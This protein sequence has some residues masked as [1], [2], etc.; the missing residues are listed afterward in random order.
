[1]TEPETPQIVSDY[2]AQ[3]VEY[4]RRAVGI[5]VEYDSDT[6]P[7]VDHYLTTV[8]PEHV[9]TTKLVVAAV[10]AYFGE[11]AR[12]HLGG[13]WEL[14][15]DS[16]ESWRLVLPIGISFAPVAVVYAAVAREESADA[17]FHIPAVL[18]SH[19]A[20]ALERMGEVSDDEY[21]SLCGRLDTLE[22]L[23][24][25]LVAVAAERKAK[26]DDLPN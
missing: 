22:H 20:S 24:G 21:Y 4:V 23:H 8:P 2:A 15:D 19:A 13:R 9:E 14:E 7:L 5:E 11:V 1:M 17:E 25:V 6:L 10:G 3:A 26:N 18:Y 16:P 12:R